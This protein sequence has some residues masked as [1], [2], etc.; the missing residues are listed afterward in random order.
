MESRQ[1]NRRPVGVVDQAGVL[2]AAFITPDT[3]ICLGGRI[4][5][6]RGIYCFPD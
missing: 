4:S 3:V 6:S 1:D 5:M 2:N